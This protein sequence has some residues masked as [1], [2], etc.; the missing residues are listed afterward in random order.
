MLYIPGDNPGMIQNAEVFGADGIL[1]DLED[2]IAES[3]KDSARK[4]VR[5]FLADFDFGK[6]FVTARINSPDTASG[7]KQLPS[8]AGLAR[9]HIGR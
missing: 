4:M 3:A 2:S 6:L 5:A 1:L 7:V 9:E 8:L